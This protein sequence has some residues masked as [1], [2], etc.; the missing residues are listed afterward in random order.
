MSINIDLEDFDDDEIM[1]Y[2]KNHLDMFESSDLSYFDSSDLEEELIGR[3]FYN[4]KLGE[5]SLTQRD[6]IDR[7]FE[8]LREEN[9]KQ[10]NK[11]LN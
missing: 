5:V 10:L 4:F 6:L 8:L 9:Y 2:A 7:F 1:D 11:R 3:G